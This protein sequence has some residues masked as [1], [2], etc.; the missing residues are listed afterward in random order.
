MDK[1]LFE[2]FITTSIKLKRLMHDGFG[3]SPTRPNV[4]RFTILQNQVLVYI[5][6]NPGVTVKNLAGRFLMSSASIAQLLARLISRKLIM[7]KQDTEDKR[8]THLYITKSGQEEIVK[9][10]M[11]IFKKASRI[12]EYIPKEDLRNMIRIQNNLL[13]QLEKEYK[14]V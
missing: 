8:I 4:T 1:K 3:T 10:K 5:S 2:E 14:Y 13:K 9:I 7:K 6:D 12:L 11:F